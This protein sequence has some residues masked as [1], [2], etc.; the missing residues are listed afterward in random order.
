MAE[1]EYFV[2]L[3]FES[4]GAAQRFLN[5]IREEMRHGGWLEDTKGRRVAEKVI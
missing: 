1:V 4:K 5:K 2:V 3:P